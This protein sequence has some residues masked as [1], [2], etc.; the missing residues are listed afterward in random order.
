MRRRHRRG[1]VTSRSQCDA[2]RR[3]LVVEVVMDATELSTLSG[4]NAETFRQAISGRE[5]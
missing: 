3:L 4:S 5:G 1:V 2:A